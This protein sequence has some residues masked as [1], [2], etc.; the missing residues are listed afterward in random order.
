MFTA[1]IRN[2]RSGE[3]Y[4]VQFSDYSLPEARK[5]IKGYYRGKHREVLAVA[6]QEVEE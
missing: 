1:L 3:R 5:Y 2:E 4:L 6:P